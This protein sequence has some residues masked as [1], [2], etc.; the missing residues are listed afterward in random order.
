M[1]TRKQPKPKK[2]AVKRPAANPTSVS[3]PPNT[4]YT[5]CA[6]LIGG[7]VTEAFAKK[8][9]VISRTIEIRGDQTLAALHT[10]LFDA[11]K[12]EEEHLYEFQVGGKGPHDPKAIRYGITRGDDIWEPEEPEEGTLEVTTTTLNDLNLKVDDVFGYWFDFGDDWFHQ[13]DVVAIESAKPNTRYP[14][15]TK[16]IGKS[17][18][19][20]ADAF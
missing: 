3:R 17:P 20:Y 16:R 4:V 14:R 8:N 12:R 11:F 5:L 18:P 10:A 6:S 2:T 15:V 19:Q 9:P 7:P 13:I 1:A